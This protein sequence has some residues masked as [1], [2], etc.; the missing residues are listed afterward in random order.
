MGYHIGAVIYVLTIVNF[1][2]TSERVGCTLNY[3]SHN[4]YCNG[5]D[6]T[7]ED[8]SCYHPVLNIFDQKIFKA[9]AS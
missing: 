6:F 8:G 2:S 7:D 4:I 9:F 5:Y 3:E 1:F